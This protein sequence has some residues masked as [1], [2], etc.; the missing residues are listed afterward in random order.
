MEQDSQTETKIR[1]KYYY[2]RSSST[3]HQGS[4]PFHKVFKARKASQ[5]Y[6]VAPLLQSTSQTHDWFQHQEYAG[7]E[8]WHTAGYLPQS[9]LQGWISP[10]DPT[11]SS[12]IFVRSGLRGSPTSC[13]SSSDSTKSLSTMTKSSVSSSSWP[14]SVPR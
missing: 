12:K 10:R 11:V 3:I 2:T 8:S 13:H 9:L 4:P 14:L 6:V 5:A 1:L 7:E